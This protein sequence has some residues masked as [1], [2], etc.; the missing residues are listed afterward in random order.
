MEVDSCFLNERNNLIFITL[1]ECSIVLVK[2]SY[3]MMDPRK[4]N[5]MAWAALLNNNDEKAM[6]SGVP[7]C[8]TESAAIKAKWL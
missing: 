5:L 1:C 6:K 8:I 2:C 7:A 3:G 4:V